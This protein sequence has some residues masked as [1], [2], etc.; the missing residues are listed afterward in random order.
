MKGTYCIPPE[1]MRSRTAAG[2]NAKGEPVAHWTFATLGGAGAIRSSAEDMLTFL[3]A[4]NGR[5][6][7]KLDAAMR[8]TQ[9]RREAVSPEMDIGLGW[10]VKR[11]DGRSYWWHNGGTGGFASYAAFC[12]EP[13]VGVVVLSNVARA[14][15]EKGGIDEIGESL[16]RQL[17][18]SGKGK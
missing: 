15:G 4:Q 8:L 2:H 18:D 13:V 10:F 17:I 5:R 7:S 1:T 14:S 9:I 12:R 3:E 16:L 6:P 11:H